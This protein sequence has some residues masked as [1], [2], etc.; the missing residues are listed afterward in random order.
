[1]SASLIEAIFQC[2]H[3]Y[4]AISKILEELHREG[5]KNA[6]V[7]ETLA[8]YKRFHP[9]HFKELE[10]QIIAALGLFYKIPEPTT[11]YALLLS[12]IGRQH[13]KEFGE[14]L[15]PVQA[16]V[17]RAINNNQYIS[18]SAPTSA[19]KSY[20]IRDFIAESTGNAVV[21]VPSRALIAEYMSNI[22]RRFAGDKAVI[23]TPFVDNI[24]KKRKLR[25]IFILTPERARELFSPQKRDLQI[26]VFFFDEAQVSEDK[27]RGIHF[28]IL[29]RRI[30]IKFPDAK[31]IFAHPFVENPDAQFLKHD[32]ST[33][34]AYARTYPQGAVGKI[35]IFRHSNGEDRYFSPFE[36]DGHL[37]TKTIQFQGNFEDYA[38]SEGH[39]ILIFV[40]KASIYDGKFINGLEHRINNF[41][42]IE[43]QAA[44]ALIERVR[45][46]LGA[47]ERDHHS[48]LVALLKKG[49]VIHH[50]S[51]PLDVR[52]VIEDFI[53]NGFAK[54]CFAT[55][56]LAQG[57]NMPF[58]IV[59][60]R[61][62]RIQG[63]SD[64]DRS[65]AFKNLIGRA[66]RLSNKPAFDYGYVYTDNPKLYRQRI[67]DSFALNET[68]ILDMPS[69]DLPNDIRE[70]VD[71]L[72]NDTFVDEFNLPA[73]KVDRLSQE[74]VLEACARILFLFYGSGTLNRDLSGPENQEARRAMRDD[75]GLIFVHAIDR[76]LLEGERAVFEKAIQIFLLAVGGKTFKE[77][78]GIRYSAVSNRSGGRAGQAKFEQAAHPLPSKKLLK[79]YPLVKNTLAKDVSYDTVVFDTYDYLDQ[80]ISFSLV[81]TFSAAFAIYYSI[82]ADKAALSMIDLLR[83]RT[84]DPKT[85]MLMRY[86][87]PTESIVEIDKYVEKVT[88]DEIVFSP[89]I[90]QANTQ[91]LEL[92]QWYL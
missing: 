13:L 39:S 23:I 89:S 56:T 54:I 73:S 57:V 60:L 84:N 27:D 49:V 87:I 46:I 53:R 77:I 42:E 92:V 68:S 40:S 44:L 12:A 28:D 34:S 33:V 43:D 18:I 3:P 69:D 55:S 59:W 90:Y 8:L 75:F 30:I 21:I 71:A 83:Y 4:G 76:Q 58:D 29:I 50:G 62:M 81:D 11:I 10:E 5:P 86:G 64:G 31:L 17:R 19:G 1:M 70:V 66:G 82:I 7:L 16:S 45:H 65:L 88:E 20:S 78:A 91:L 35:S 85:I 14:R 80:V 67:N 2:E 6:D 72:R 41:P 9:E 74:P 38:F 51:V 15:T 47:D 37:L 22:K 79:P 32:I 26:K 48:R 24:F 25:H 61:S 63:E 52:F 36:E